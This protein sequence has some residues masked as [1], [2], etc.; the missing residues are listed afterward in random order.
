MPSPSSIAMEDEWGTGTK[1]APAK[2]PDSFMVRKPGGDPSQNLAIGEPHFL[3]EALDWLYQ[4]A[5]TLPKLGYQYPDPHGQ[6]DLIQALKPDHGEHILVTN[7]AKQG[8]A[9]LLYAYRKRGADSIHHATPFWPTYKT[10]AAESRLLFLTNT[11][12]VNTNTVRVLTSPNN[13]DGV[14]SVGPCHIWDA[15]YYSPAYSN[16]LQVPQHVASVWSA[17][18]LLGVPG[19]R[20]GWVRTKDAEL[21]KLV[22]EYVELT[23]SG[24]CTLAQTAVAKLLTR[25]D[26]YSSQFEESLE[27]ARDVL[28]TNRNCLRAALDGDHTSFNAERGM[29]EVVHFSHADSKAEFVRRMKECEASYLPGTVVGLDDNHVRMSLGLRYGDMTKFINR[30]LIAGLGL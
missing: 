25:A 18:K 12:G 5:W 6:T 11:R 21:A 24:V 26:L 2:S 19:M 8:I 13:P 7:G 16:T 4:D 22:S 14:V 30:Y 10:L 28:E 23:T 1:E 20:V 17:A 27:Q 9:A 3:R 15:A 29:F